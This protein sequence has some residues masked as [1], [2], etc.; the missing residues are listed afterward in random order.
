M[1]AIISSI[2]ALGLAVLTIRLHFLLPAKLEKHPWQQTPQSRELNSAESVTMPLWLAWFPYVLTVILLVLPKFVPAIHHFLTNQ[3][4]LSWM[5]ILGFKTINSEWLLLASP[6]TVLVLV[7]IVT[8]LIHRVSWADFGTETKQVV[9]SM[10]YTV[11]ALVVTLVM[12]QVFTNS[13]INTSSLASMPEFLAEKLAHAFSG[14]WLGIAPLLGGLGSFVTG[15]TTVS[16]LTFAPVQASVAKDAGLDVD[17]V[18]ALQV[19]GASIGN[20]ICIHNIVA[21]SGVVGLTG[22]E[23]QVLRENALPVLFYFGLLLVAIMIVS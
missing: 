16:T 5:K 8:L 6:G 21:V 18:L 20:M 7:A 14:I 1:V 3:V 12:V 23:G 11:L 15:S 10:K 19:I 9:V 17:L 4:N 2:G 22:K 13:G